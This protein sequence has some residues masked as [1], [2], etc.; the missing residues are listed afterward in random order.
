MSIFRHKAKERG[1]VSH[2]ADLTRLRCRLTAI[3][4]FLTCSTLVVMLVVAWV[5]SAST[6]RNSDASALDDLLFR[7]QLSIDD[8][9]DA[10]SVDEE[11]SRLSREIGA[12]MLAS[13]HPTS[14][15]TD[16]DLSLHRA[17]SRTPFRF[18]ALQD[19]S[20]RLLDRP[21]SVSMPPRDEER[22]ALETLV[23]T[24]LEEREAG[25]TDL[26]IQTIE[27]DDRTWIWSTY[28]ACLDPDPNTWRSGSGDLPYYQSGDLQDYLDD[29][30]LAGRIYGF[31]DITPSLTGLHDLAATLAKTGIVGFL[32]LIAIC[33]WVVARALAPAEEAQARQ[34]EFIGRASHELK[35]PLA[36]LTSNLDA[37]VLNG[38]KTVASQVR[39]TD[40]MRADVDQM[41]GLACT[42]LDVVD[43][44]GPMDA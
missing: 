2:G 11:L 5:S 19:G 3:S 22:A 4:S 31:V 26:P 32:L 33:R 9:T 15:G 10:A 23:A 24:V 37:L 40:N 17:F 41:A 25:G 36:S 12:E 13:L 42:L 44:K 21:A 14:Y 8:F 39:W 43:A 16:G 1:D 29:G 20:I 35:T 27:Y 38:D 28:T 34:H 30:L 18:F 7:T 6:A